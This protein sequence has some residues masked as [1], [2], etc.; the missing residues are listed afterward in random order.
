VRPGGMESVPLS[1]AITGASS[2]RTGVLRL[3][4]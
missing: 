3:A 1:R 4:R 2:S